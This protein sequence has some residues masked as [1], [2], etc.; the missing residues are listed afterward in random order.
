MTT[1]SEYL[2]SRDAPCPGCGH[3][4]RGLPADRCP[5]C[6]SA[7][8]LGVLRPH[9]GRG[10]T[11]TLIGLSMGLGQGLM[12][13]IYFVLILISGGVLP[14]WLPACF[15]LLT[16]S[17]GVV[18]AFVLRR[19]RAWGRLPGRARSAVAALAVILGLALPAGL[20]AVAAFT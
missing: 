10:W 8:E 12:A 4:L 11:L 18:L 17:S 3:A 15:A 7:L 1:L 6:G 13:C 9:P 20:M 16:L 2:A 5:E 19:E 14:I